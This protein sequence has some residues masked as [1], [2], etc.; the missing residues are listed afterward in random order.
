MS[1]ENVAVDTILGG[2]EPVDPTE[3]HTVVDPEELITVTL[4]PEIKFT[5]YTGTKTLL[6]F[7]MCLG[8]YNTYRGWAM[9]EDEDPAA[10]GYLV[11]YADGYQ[12]WSP[13]AAFEESYRPSGTWKE[14]LQIE[15][16]QL[17]ARIAAL[18]AFLMSGASK[19]LNSMEVH[20]LRQQL[21]AMK[22]YL[23]VL[24]SRK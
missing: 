8:V 21:T 11:Q 13:A 17:S 24:N 9:P 20:N 23:G 19:S 1:D 14:R 6:A 22:T 10:Q 4:V 2:P 15:K 3:E 5:Q 12:S 18:A 16:E 7:P